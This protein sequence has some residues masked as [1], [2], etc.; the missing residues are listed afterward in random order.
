MRI[1][2][3]LMA[4]AGAWLLLIGVPARPAVAADDAASFIA[5]TA[6]KVLTLARNQQLPQEEFKKQLHA[7]ADQ[8]FDTPRIAQFVL[9]R[10]WRTASEAERQQFI[11]AFEDYMVNVYAT[12]FRQ[13][14][15]AKFKVNGQREEGN[16]AMVSTEIDQGNGKPPAKIVW[17]LEKAPNGYKITDVNIEG[18]SQA[19]TYRQEFSSVL[20]Q[21]G[22]QI[23]ALTQSLRQKANG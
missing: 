12:R 15:G 17:Q 4:L 5:S 18:V 9:G 1:S 6:D 11:Q 13:Y 8:D 16:T 20:A 3:V 7:I 23:S 10:Y 22:G 14:S 21:Q 19:I 2:P